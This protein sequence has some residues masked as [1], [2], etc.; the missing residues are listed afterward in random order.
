MTG[1][2]RP[3]SASPSR[4]VTPCANSATNSLPAGRPHER[5]RRAPA[6]P[7][8]LPWRLR[9]SGPICGLRDVIEPQPRAHIGEAFVLDRDDILVKRCCEKRRTAYW[10][11]N[12][13]K[14]GQHSAYLVAAPM[15]TSDDTLLGVLVVA[16]CPSCSCKDENLL[17]VS[18]LLAYVAD[19]A[20][21]RVPPRTCCK[22]CRNARPG[23]PPRPSSSRGVRAT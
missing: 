11:A 20:K 10:A 19:D 1:S 18:V 8:R 13:L 16:T 14:E 7:D 17:T 9:T 2:N 12:S 3:S 22:A 4:C 6:A 21:A 5:T 15:L 23:S